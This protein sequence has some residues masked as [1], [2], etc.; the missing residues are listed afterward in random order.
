MPS[1]SASTAL[2]TSPCEQTTTSGSGTGLWRPGATAAAAAGVHPVGGP[3]GAARRA[4]RPRP[5]GRAVGADQVADGGDRPRGHPGERLAAGEP[6][7]GRVLLDHAPELLLGEVLERAAGPLAVVHLGEPVV[8][9]DRQPERVGQRL[10]ACRRQR[11]SGEDTSRSIVASRSR[12]R[13][14]PPAGGRCRRAGR[15]GAGPASTPVVLRSTAVPD[16]HDGGHRAHAG[17]PVAVIQPAASAMIRPRAERPAVPDERPDGVPGDEPEHPG[18]REVGDDEADARCRP[19][20]ARSR[21]PRR[22]RR[23]APPA[24]RRRP[25]PG[26]PAGS[27][28]W[29][30]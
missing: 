2:M 9:L 27:R 22:A 17:T 14:R 1:A 4:P 20:S 15:P 12:S 13:S 8:G 16:Q 3:D 6:G 5:A 30:R 25:G 7:R 10:R 23:P 26:C 19:G 21:P 24:S 29:R 28:I 11:S 18:H